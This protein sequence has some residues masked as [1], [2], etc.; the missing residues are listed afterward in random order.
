LTDKT[1]Q[2]IEDPDGYSSRLGELLAL[3]SHARRCLTSIHTELRD[4]YLTPQDV[5][6]LNTR[7]T[8]RAQLATFEEQQARRRR[9]LVLPAPAIRRRQADAPAG[10]IDNNNGNNENN[11]RYMWRKV[12][13]SVVTFLAVFSMLLY[14]FYWLGGDAYFFPYQ[15]E[16]NNSSTS[17]EPF[18]PFNFTMVPKCT[19]YGELSYDEACNITQVERVRRIATGFES[20]CNLWDEPKIMIFVG[21]SLVTITWILVV[22]GLLVLAGFIVFDAVTVQR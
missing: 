10:E 13:L 5:F 17:S 6:D 9:G 2:D 12:A 21:T 8:V 16:Q 11:G 18:P 1:A 7:P 22:L 3:N 19:A 4:V 15:R 20:D 14:F